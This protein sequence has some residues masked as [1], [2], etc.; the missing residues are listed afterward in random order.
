MSDAE[1]DSNNEH[2]EDINNSLDESTNDTTSI[3][4]ST[5][6]V[7]LNQLKTPSPHSHDIQTPQSLLHSPAYASAYGAS[8]YG[9]SAYGASAYAPSFTPSFTPTNNESQMTPSTPTI[10][11]HPSLR[12]Q[13][14]PLPNTPSLDSVLESRREELA[15][16]KA[17]REEKDRETGGVE[18]V[19]ISPHISPYISY[20]Y[21]TNISSSRSH[22]NF[23][24][25]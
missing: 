20:M 15:R 23:L 5:S 25:Y 19:R 11:F 9:A 13:N 12:H 6:T 4:Q 22:T 16:L 1:N 14:H 10:S 2:F 18:K 7:P 8:A 3:N 21:I 24:S 17:L